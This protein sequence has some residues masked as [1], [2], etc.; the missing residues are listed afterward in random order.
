MEQFFFWIKIQMF[1]KWKIKS[2][3]PNKT[4]LFWKM[5]FRKMASN[6]LFDLRKIKNS[7]TTIFKEYLFFLDKKTDVFE[8]KNRKFWVK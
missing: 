6:K 5:N 1:L 7:G 3:G 4:T 2:F 8:I